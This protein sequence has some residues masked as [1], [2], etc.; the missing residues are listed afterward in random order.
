MS[1]PLSKRLRA[2]LKYVE[3]QQCGR[4]DIGFIDG[5]TRPIDPLV[6]YG[7]LRRDGHA[8]VI[9]DDGREE[10]RR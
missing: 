7:F 5:S 10:L 9:T 2:F 1:K 8:I 6:K 4:I 3:D